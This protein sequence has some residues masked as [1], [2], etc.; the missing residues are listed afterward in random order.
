MA[1][2]HSDPWAVGL[3]HERSATSQRRKQRGAFYTPR[4]VVEGLLRLAVP[5]VGSI[6]ASVLDPTCG[7]GAFLLGAADRMV[8]LGLDP[9]EALRRLWALDIDP[10]AVTAT[11]AALSVWAASHGVVNADIASHVL[12]GDALAGLPKNVPAPE[13]VVGNPPFA[14]P[15]KGTVFPDTATAYR[16]RY[17]DL[18][19]PYI[20]L[21]GLHLH[22]AAQLCST[23]PGSKIAFVLPQS[24]LAARDGAGLRAEF[25]E[26]TQL[27]ALWATD[28]ALFDAN[29]QVC[30][31]VID[32]SPITKDR[33]VIIANGPDVEPVV[34]VKPTEAWSVYA[35]SALG[36]P[37]VE[38][39]GEPLGALVSATAGFRDEYYALAAACCEEADLP[40]SVSAD[41]VI[42]IAT[43]GS[44][45]PLRFW[46]GERP[47]RF[48]KRKWDRPAVDL[49]K[50]EGN[51]RMQSWLG[52]QL[53]PKLLLPTQSKVFE[54]VIDRNGTMAP[55]TPVL[56]LHADAEDLDRLAAV[57]LAPPIVLWAYRRW[58]G[59][60]LSVKA[61]K[62]AARHIAEFPRPEDVAKWEE[63]AQLVGETVGLEPARKRQQILAIASLM[64]DAYGASAE[65]LQWWS[66]RY[67]AT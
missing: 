35:A 55:V 57:F 2:S 44:L 4:A 13:L 1:V 52:E 46:W 41:E 10:G 65:V 19:G 45:D 62:V 59:T 29:I 25:L 38:I 54:P 30:G 17:P 61:I 60:A 20:D 51:E 47:T 66:E 37:E 8:A 9:S 43:V 64:N 23:E 67:E 12:V 42:R 7:G 48:A 18:F 21:A 32:T 11:T 39:E 14:T 53:R 58:F 40:G 26:T 56:A 15:L 49:E 33:R 31:L 3:S 28:V 16:N 6:P 22:S 24:I 27:L 34:A 36:A 5:D 63:A 50:I